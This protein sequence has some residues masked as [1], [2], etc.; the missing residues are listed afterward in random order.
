MR[1]AGWGTQHGGEG[2]R[3][4]R[5]GWRASRELLLLPRDR[6]KRKEAVRIRIASKYNQE[7]NSRWRRARPAGDGQL[8]PRN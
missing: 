6:T 8:A 1:V 2:H 7:K 4:D 3:R 5:V